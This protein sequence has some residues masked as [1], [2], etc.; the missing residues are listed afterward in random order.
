MFY[1]L[2][3]A[4]ISPVLR[5]AMAVIVTA[6]CAWLL[7]S[8]YLDLDG[9]ASLGFV[10]VANFLPSFWVCMMVFAL[11]AELNWSYFDAKPFERG[12]KLYQ[13]LGAVAFRDFLKRVGWSKAN[14]SPM[15]SLRT[16]KGKQQFLVF[17]KMA[18]LAHLVPLPL[19]FWLTWQAIRRQHWASL[20]VL[21]FINLFVHIY[22]IMLQRY[23][24]PITV[25][26]IAESSV[27]A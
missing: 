13:S 20:A 16:D 6:F 7:V 17:T 18:E 26:K 21:T 8:M 14:K 12:G 4:D 27:H 15:E 23:N 2:Y 1:K 10:V 24:R 3:D 25:Q 19:T 5:W 22:P 11:S 9:T